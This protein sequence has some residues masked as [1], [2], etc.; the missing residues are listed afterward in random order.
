MIDAIIGGATSVASGIGSLIGSRKADLRNENAAN[1]S[2]QR[3]YEAQKEFAQNS[4]QWRMQD[5]KKAGINPYAVVGGQSPG[6]TPQDSSY[7]SSYG[8]GISKAM[9]GIENAM[10]QLQMANVRAE[11]EGKQIDNAKKIIELINQGSQARLG[12]VETTISPTHS[13]VVGDVRS[14]KHLTMPS[15]SQS[16]F[17]DVDDMNLSNLRQALGGYNRDYVEAIKDI[18]SKKKIEGKIGL[19]LAGY[20]FNPKGVYV[21]PASEQAAKF[22]DFTGYTAAGLGAY[23]P[24]LIKDLLVNMGKGWINQSKTKRKD[25]SNWDSLAH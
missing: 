24:L 1:K 25:Y 17:P 2:W 20:T 13:D 15:G 11:L 18:N 21:S 5:A 8:E 4:I 6:Y 12:Q 22:A 19:D 16:Y 14:G 23:V 3:N 7:N 9:N 10:G